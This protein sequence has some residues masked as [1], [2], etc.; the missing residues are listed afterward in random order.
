[1]SGRN[2]A[3]ECYLAKVDVDGSNPFARSSPYWRH[4]QVAKAAVCKTVIHR[5]ESGSR[6]QF[7][8]PGRPDS[9]R[10]LSS[11]STQ[12]DRTREIMAKAKQKKAVVETESPSLPPPV[13]ETESPSTPPPVV[14]D[15]MTH[16]VTCCQEGRW[17]EAALAARQMLQQAEEAGHDEFREGFDGAMQKIDYSLRRQMAIAV[18]NAS[19][20]FL[21]KECLL[22][23]AE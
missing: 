17:R 1:M 6:L 3:V 16:C 19:K 18:V 13:V 9:A 23:V 7:F 8:L 14:E 21:K 15:P 22:D 5:F 4:S 11:K 20:E 10:L 2:S 12:L